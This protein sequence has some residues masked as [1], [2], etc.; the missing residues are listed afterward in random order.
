MAQTIKKGVLEMKAPLSI[1][2]IALLLL[3]LFSC[4]KNSESDTVEQPP[5]TSI[6]ADDTVPVEKLT[7]KPTILNQ[8]LPEYPEVAKQAGIEGRAVIQI[9]VLEDGSVGDDAK[10]LQSSGNEALD[11]SAITAAK[12]F[13]F[14]PGKVDDRA[15]KTHLAIP[16]QFS[17]DE[18]K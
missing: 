10:V 4:S 6:I 7:S 8:A 13:K 11:Q 5:A 14:S 1:L 3:V 2:S 16:F 12:A 9:T 15:V 18:K 17:L